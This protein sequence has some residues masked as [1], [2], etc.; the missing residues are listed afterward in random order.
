MPSPHTRM[1]LTLSAELRAAL[2]DLAEAWEKPA[3]TVATELLT[4][5]IPQL[6]GMAK[7]ARVAK[8]GNTAAVKRALAQMV[9]DS[10]AGMMVAHQAELDLARSAVKLAPKV[11]KGNKK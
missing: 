2:F 5:M 10:M 8:S 7:L 3:S 1:A 9:G 11:G 6:E 4:E